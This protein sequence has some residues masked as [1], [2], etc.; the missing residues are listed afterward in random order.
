MSGTPERILT[1]RGA[2]L[3]A[4]DA[5]LAAVRDRFAATAAHEAHRFEVNRLWLEYL[6]LAEPV[7]APII[8]R[9]LKHDMKD[10][11]MPADELFPEASVSLGPERILDMN[12][13][14]CT[15][16]AEEERVLASFTRRLIEIAVVAGG[17]ELGAS[18]AAALDAM[19]LPAIAINQD[20]F[21]VEVNATADAVFDQNIKIKDKRLFVR[22]P[23]SRA[24]LKS[25]IDQLKDLPRLDS[26][27]LE[28]VIVPRMDKL[29]VIVRVWPFDGP[30]STSAGPGS[31][32]YFDVKCLGAKAR[33]VRGDPRQDI[34]ADT[35]GSKGR[36]H[37]RAGSP[38]ISPPGS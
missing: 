33:T 21:V 6:E 13:E 29:P 32:C 12:S 8:R 9:L 20:G 10:A 30:A 38:P 16:V 27:A 5:W 18:P 15:L 3:A 14:I 17:R 35:I 28:P 34:P 7:R 22:D 36:L 1:G 11:G 25:A 4:R 31:A 23:G 2:W 19:R 37:H 26:L 24:L